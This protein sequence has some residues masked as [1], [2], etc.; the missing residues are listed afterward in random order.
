MRIA[1]VLPDGERNRRFNKLQK[2]HKQNKKV[3]NL[4][5]QRTSHWFVNLFH[6]CSLSANGEVYGN[7]VLGLAKVNHT[8]LA[9]I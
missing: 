4:P 6:E 9:P 3:R 1:W 8:G 7:T 2:A 5:G